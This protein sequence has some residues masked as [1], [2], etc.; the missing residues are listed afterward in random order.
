MRIGVLALQ[1]AVREHL[2]ALEEAGA[3]AVPVKR[4]AEL[5]GLE[6]V[7]LPGGESTTIGMLLEEYGFSE[8]LRSGIPIFGTCAGLILLA[9]RIR[10]SDQPRLG[11]LDVEVERNGF[12]RQ[13]E[14]FETELSVPVLGAEPLTA[15]FIRAPYVTQAGPGVEVLARLEERIVLVREGP[16]LG[17]AFHPELTTDRRL[18]RYFLDMIGR[19]A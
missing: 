13:R 2:R 11:L 10:R 18:H 12:G 3:E 7:V 16:Y 15:V 19:R 4:P 17:S 8:P 6:G 9:K 1:G 5:R 14:S